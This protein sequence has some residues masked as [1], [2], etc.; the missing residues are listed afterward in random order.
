[1][2]VNVDDPARCV[3]RAC[4]YRARV[5]YLTWTGRTPYRGA[6]GSSDAVS[7]I[8]RK[9]R[10]IVG[11]YPPDAGRRWSPVCESLPR[12]RILVEPVLERAL[13]RGVEGVEAVKGKRFG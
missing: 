9:G 5:A 12:H 1:M 7:R 10:T 8:Q 4:T 13:D 6:A 11:A 3:P 2:A